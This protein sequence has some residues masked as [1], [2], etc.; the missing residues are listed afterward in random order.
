VYFISLGWVQ[1]INGDVHVIHRRYDVLRFDVL[2]RDRSFG[3]AWCPTTIVV[4][5]KG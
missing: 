5:P 3:I 1:L 2:P 4:E